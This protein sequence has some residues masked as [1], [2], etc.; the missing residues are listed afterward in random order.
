M[1]KNEH[2]I[3]WLTQLWIIALKLNMISKYPFASLQVI[4]QWSEMEESPTFQDYNMKIKIVGSEDV[5]REREG[6]I[7]FRMTVKMQQY[8][9]S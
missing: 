3:I 9:C 6:R 8:Y 4:L 7:N 1:N 2:I 5:W